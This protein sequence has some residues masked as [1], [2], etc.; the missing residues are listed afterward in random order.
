MYVCGTCVHFSRILQHC[1]L[2]QIVPSLA[3]TM[4]APYT[5]QYTGQYVPQGDAYRQQYTQSPGKPVL[6]RSISTTNL[7]IT[8][9]CQDYVSN[10]LCASIPPGGTY[11]FMDLPSYTFTI[12]PLSSYPP[13]FRQFV[14]DRIVDKM[15][16]KSLE[17]ESCLN[18]CH[19]ATKLEPLHTKGDGNCLL[20]A[21]SL[22]MWGFQ[23]RANILRNAVSKAVSHASSKSN[24]LY[25]R[26]HYNKH[27]E[28][29]QQGYRLEPPQWQREWETVVRQASSDP[30]ATA[31]L[32]SLEEFHVFVLANVLRRPVIMYASRKMRSIHSGGT[33]QCINFHGV[34]LPLLWDPT[35]CKKDPLPLGYQS[36]HFSALVVVDFHQ[37]YRDG[38]LIL[39]LVSCD[40]QPLPVR[41]MLHDESPQSLLNDYIS[42]INIHPHAV[43]PCASLSVNTKP[44]YYDRLVTAFI[45]ACHDAFLQQQQVQYPYGKGM[46]GGGTGS[47]ANGYPGGGVVGRDGRHAPIGAT[48][49][50]EE[51]C[52]GVY[53]KGVVQDSYAQGGA[54]VGGNNSKVKC[55]NNCG[56]FGDQETAGLCSKCYKKSLDAAQQQEKPTSQAHL[57]TSNSGLSS[58]TTSG[59]IKCPNCSQPGHPKFLGMCE[60]CYHGTQVGSQQQVWQQ[61]ATQP[62][63]SEYGNQPSEPQLY[64]QPQYRNQP[65]QPMYGNQ[66]QPLYGNEGGVQPQYGNQGALQQPRGN[67]QPNNAYESLDQYQKQVSPPAHTAK[68]EP[69]PP[70]PL[71]RSTASVMDRNKCRT[72]NC[73]FFGTA[74]TRFYCSKCFDRD[75]VAILNEVNTPARPPT[76]VSDQPYQTQPSPYHAQQMGT[77]TGPMGYATPPANTQQ[78]PSEKC[79]KCREY[80]GAPEY[81]GLC[82]GCFKNKTKEDANPKKCPKCYEFFGSDEYGG[83]CN[84]CFLKKTEHETANPVA[85]GQPLG[86]PAPSIASQSSVGQDM[87]LPAPAFNFGS[88]VSIPPLPP[89][90]EQPLQR[91]QPNY[92]GVS[93][94][95]HGQAQNPE[96][97]NQPGYL[98][99]APSQVGS[100]SYAQPQGPN[101]RP[102]PKPRSR[103]A[104]KMNAPQQQPVVSAH[105]Y[106]APIT[107]AVNLTPAVAA[108]NI[109]NSNPN[110]TA[111]ICFLCT[112]TNPQVTKSYF[113]CQKHAQLMTQQFP[114]VQNQ[115]MQQ[116]PTIPSSTNQFPASQGGHM[117]TPLGYNS[118]Q[119]HIPP[120]GENVGRVN[121]LYNSPQAAASGQ[122]PTAAMKQKQHPP[123]QSHL[124]PHSS[125]GNIGGTNLPYNPSQADTYA[126]PAAGGYPG[127]RANHPQPNPS[128]TGGG[129]AMFNDLNTNTSGT[130]ISAHQ[131]EVG[132][133]GSGVHSG[134]GHGVMGGGRSHAII[135]GGG[136]GIIGGSAGSIGIR[137][138]VP[139]AAGDSGA[140]GSTPN[141]KLPKLLCKTAG[142]SFYANPDLEHLCSNCYEE[143]YQ[144]KAPEEKP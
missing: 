31:T 30:T 77:G 120:R 73:E 143:Y 8:R 114:L 131:E 128:T 72:P 59:S 135:G 100:Q 119:P 74:E 113:V 82:H 107:D 88:D 18:W 52:Y 34:Y 130:G 46:N 16:K 138:G 36:G 35:S 56:M 38:K 45:E 85:K 105:M 51:S 101:S 98:F 67:E 22:G 9:Q 89:K 50:P 11:F 26:W 54:G 29:Q 17:E 21:A 32:Y 75:M 44:T 123:L 48:I 106:T 76:P 97:Y 19:Q 79:N 99:A 43:I 33:M 63:Q 83:L 96:S 49:G 12:P 27:L 94:A 92:T 1:S 68:E 81:G 41:F 62:H 133:A 71:P 69:P 4:T 118:A 80:F 60:S 13:D 6:P 65:A 57:S 124:S 2:F 37:Q 7:E 140:S 47:G 117:P 87:N 64:L 95:Q 93:P 86:T 23:D 66:Q 58:L 109:S 129:R 139:T 110:T 28:C 144:M 103:T 116:N 127:S 137:A 142:C 70:V 90:P 108:I 111:E 115:N 126:Q 10:D 39:P 104:M 25:Q 53:T 3:P 122:Y 78:L 20:H 136:G 40:G 141:T 134:Q 61:P 14:F 125:A 55:I 24:T 112:N 132:T 84:G 15:A 121:L 91:V 42:I 102:V 5:E